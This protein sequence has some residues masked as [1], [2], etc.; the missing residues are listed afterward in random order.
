MPKKVINNYL[1]EILKLGFNPSKPRMVTVNLTNRCDQKCIYCEIG[2]GSPSEAKGSLNFN[3]LQWIINEMKKIGIKKISLC[4]GEPFLFNDLI[5]VV[6]YASGLGIRTSITTNGMIAHQMNP[7]ELKILKSCNTEVNVSLDSFD[8]AI[9]NLTRG[10]QAALP[11]ALKTLKVLAENDIPVTI[12]TAISKYNYHQLHEFTLDAHTKGIRQ[13][14]FQPIIYYSNYPDRP[15][16]AEKSGL[17]VDL[18]NFSFLMTELKRILK[19]ERTHRIETNVYRILPWIRH[20]LQTAAGLNGKWFFENVLEVFYCREIYAIIDI[21][22][23]GGIQPC[24]L[25]RASVSIHQNRELGLLTLW[26]KATE[27]IRKNMEEKRYYDFC[28]GCCHHFSRNMLAS[29]MK[30][31]I[32]NRAAL[33]EIAPLLLKRASSRAMKK[34]IKK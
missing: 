6:E 2:T 22:Y 18:E 33:R 32:K 28:N 25:A 24:G 11:N 20:Y 12:L 19:Y 5:P 10:T 34:F 14:L 9:N 27:E 13:V 1:P 7:E 30:Y 8:P 4:G 23:D 3:D 26:E 16:I 15:V 31:P 29:V 17:N 21:T